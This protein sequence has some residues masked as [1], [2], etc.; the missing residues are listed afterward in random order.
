MC[1][2]CM[3]KSIPCLVLMVGSGKMDWIFIWVTR[4][5]C[6]KEKLVSGY[7]KKGHGDFLGWKTPNHLVQSLPWGE[8]PEKWH[9]VRSQRCDSENPLP[10]KDIRF[11]YKIYSSNEYHIFRRRRVHY[12][13]H[14][15]V[16][17]GK[18]S[19][20]V[21]WLSLI[22]LIACGTHWHSHCVCGSREG[23]GSSTWVSSHS[24]GLGSP[25]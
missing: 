10:N 20:C 6:I 16:G 5:H 9:G 15:V 4:L 22:S 19:G 13:L 7:S 2:W 18:D 12:T 25:V 11:W 21:T 17:V 3:L 23:L 8:I 24:W 14:C 1:G